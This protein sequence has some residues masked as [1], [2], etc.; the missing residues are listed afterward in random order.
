MKK[1][2]AALASSLAL[3]AI[4]PATTIAH[5][6][7]ND[8][9][10]SS[11]NGH[12]LTN[13]NSSTTLSGGKANFTGS[14]TGLMSAADSAAWDDISFTV[15][16]T[17]TF[18]TPSTA[19]IS[20]LAAHLSNTTGRQWLFGTNTAN[21]PVLLLREAG[22]TTEINFASSFGAL[23]SGNTYYFGAA[24]DLAASNPADRVT[25]YF[26]DLT[27]DGAF[28]TQNFSTTITSLE[29]SSALLS[30]GSTSHDA[31]SSRLTG[32]IDEL[33]FSDTK[34]GPND[35]LIAPVP[36]PSAALLS[37][38]AVSLFGLRRKRA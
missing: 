10:D 7:F 31:P 29:N 9:T 2:L 38:F 16:S 4:A 23:T 33:R 26:R 25:L 11:G 8:L 15:E 34:L 35:L 13:T 20:T 36:E 6:Q 14:G 32:A 22:G 19:G 27:N 21:V 1:T 3:S 12:N 5:W 28:L 18:T 30:I 37:V 17:F 24:I